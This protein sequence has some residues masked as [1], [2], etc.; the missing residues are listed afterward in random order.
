MTLNVGSYLICHLLWHRTHSTFCRYPQRGWYYLA[1][2]MTPRTLDFEIGYM[3]DTFYAS[4]PTVI[5]TREVVKSRYES[6]KSPVPD[7]VI[8]KFSN[9]FNF[10]GFANTHHVADYTYSMLG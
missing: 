9:L 6:R 1:H 10:P 7:H 4:C 8:P 3:Y 2:F 5:P